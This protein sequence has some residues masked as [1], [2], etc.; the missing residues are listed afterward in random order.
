[1][2]TDDDQS[3]DVAA[4]KRPDDEALLTVA[5]AARVA[6]VSRSTFYRVIRDKKLNAVTVDGGGK[7]VALVEVLAAFSISGPEPGDRGTVNRPPAQAAP[8]LVIVTQLQDALQAEQAKV[9]QLERQL[10]TVQ[11]DQDVS[12]STSAPRQHELPRRR[13]KLVRSLEQ[14]FDVLVGGTL[15]FVVA[16]VLIIALVFSFGGFTDVPTISNF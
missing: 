7:R 11:E 1:M 9:Q 2:T 16:V 6:G 14:T 10:A 12:A 4:A 15:I 8:D 5:D 3:E 13:W